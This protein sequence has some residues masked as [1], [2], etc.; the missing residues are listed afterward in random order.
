MITDQIRSSRYLI[1]PCRYRHVRSYPNRHVSALAC[2][3]YPSA[4]AMWAA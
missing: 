4:L 3:R 1:D 2:I